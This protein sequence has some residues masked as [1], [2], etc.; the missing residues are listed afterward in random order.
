MR[1]ISHFCYFAKG[2]SFEISNFVGVLSLIWRYLHSA[3]LNFPNYLH[4]QFAGYISRIEEKFIQ[5]FIMHCTQLH[6][7]TVMNITWKFCIVLYYTILY[8]TVL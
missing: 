3:K 6:H 8:N 4:F 7:G 2:T 5:H 1:E